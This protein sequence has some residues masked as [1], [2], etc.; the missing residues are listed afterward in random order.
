VRIR[1]AIPDRHLDAD[2]IDAVLEATTRAAAKQ[3]AAGEAPDARDAIERGLKWRPEPYDDGEHFDLPA[4]T[5]KR[6][7]A[8]C[9][10][11]G[12][13]LAASLRV[14]GED[15]GARAVAYRSGPG[16]WHVVT[17]MSDGRILDPSKWAGMRK[18]VSPGV[19]GGTIRPMAAHGRGAVALAQAA[20]GA[21]VGRCD[22]PWP[23]TQTHLAGLAR[24]RDPR[25]AVA[26][27]IEGSALCCEGIG[28][29]VDAAWEVGD[30]L[31]GDL[32]DTAAS[33][34]VPGGGEALEAGKAIAKGLGL[35][36]KDI[37]SVLR[38][39]IEE[40]MAKHID[41]EIAKKEAAHDL[42]GLLAM[43][44]DLAS[45]N[46]PRLAANAMA[47]AKRLQPDTTQKTAPVDM[48]SIV[49]QFVS[50]GRGM[51]QY[52]PGGGPIVVR[53]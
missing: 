52:S 41:P 37:H 51:L 17:R 53:F 21:W 1:L 47:A 10:D 42:A 28:G 18:G 7:W 35:G 39:K 32:L 34:A 29:E 50:N 25:T 11:L 33:A 16:R 22:L 4:T 30:C 31:V 38:D 13:H 36:G 48:A 3:I 45:K 20:N 2:V 26:R 9:D 14:T 46:M 27:A 12:P 19:A 8:D 5:V 6:R 49:S 24:A 23:S 43:G 15:E 44:H 40:G